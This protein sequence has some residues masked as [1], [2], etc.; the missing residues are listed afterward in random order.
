MKS[1]VVKRSIRI[2]GHKTRVSIEDGFWKSL[3]EIASERHISLSD[4]IAAIETDRQHSNLS[5]AI[6]LFVL[7]FYR[8]KVSAK[9]GG[10]CS[11]EF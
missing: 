5:S 11:T 9:L 4:L 8:G 2:A 3:K 6:R 1:S 10:E 7:E